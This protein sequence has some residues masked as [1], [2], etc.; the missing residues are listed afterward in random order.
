M[1]ILDIGRCTNPPV[2]EEEE[3]PDNPKPPAPEPQKE[4]PYLSAIAED[5]WTTATYVHGGPAVAV[6]RCVQWPGAYCAFSKAKGDKEMVSSFY[7][8]YG[9]ESLPKAFKME[10]PPAF[11]LEP[12][13]VHEQQDATL[14]EENADY[15]K[16]LEAQVAEKAAEL[17][18]PEPEE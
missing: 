8:G 10:A 1:G 3:D 6:A 17:P 7:V 4:M 14:E 15:R 16:V 12:E 2:E 13:E 11:E 9:H 18:D 5:A